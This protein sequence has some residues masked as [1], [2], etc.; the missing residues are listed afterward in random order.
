VISRVTPP[1]FFQALG[2]SDAPRISVD[3]IIRNGR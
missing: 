3:V 2:A 1:P